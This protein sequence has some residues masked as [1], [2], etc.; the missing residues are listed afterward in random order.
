MNEVL[1]ASSQNI[2]NSDVIEVLN[3]SYNRYNSIC[4][5]PGQK[6]ISHPTSRKPSHRLEIKTLPKQSQ[7]I[8]EEDSPNLLPDSPYFKSTSRSSH[9]PTS[10][11][12]RSIPRQLRDLRYKTGSTSRSNR[13]YGS[14]DLSSPIKCSTASP[15]KL[16]HP[17]STRAS[18]KP[19][20]DLSR[21][22][23]T[24]A[25]RTRLNE[26]DS[27]LYR[28]SDINTSSLKISL[29]DNVREFNEL[30]SSLKELSG[31]SPIK[32]A[33]QIPEVRI[34]AHIPASDVF[35]NK[36]VREQMRMWRIERKKAQA[37]L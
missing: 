28:L 32:P 35:S 26:L 21:D 25:T 16:R 24:K 30:N 29:I 34:R 31:T 15:I 27:I 23:P 2:P 33:P 7:R 36:K 22:S 20:S 6:S 11:S 5:N 18:M 4:I 37:I 14:L 9:Y 17:L 1:T 3:L 8:H 19:S 13:A 10:N 12:P